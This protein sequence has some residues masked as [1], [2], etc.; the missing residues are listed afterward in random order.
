MSSM[1]QR[2]AGNV[3]KQGGVATQ[4]GAAG[5]TNAVG[6]P[7]AAFAVSSTTG[8]RGPVGGPGGPWLGMGHPI[9]DLSEVSAWRLIA[10]G[11]AVAYIVGF[12]VTLGRTRLGLGPAR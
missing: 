11:V 3:I 10:V 8:Q 9:F 12:H 2:G 6:V 7:R 4:D 1:R 5:R